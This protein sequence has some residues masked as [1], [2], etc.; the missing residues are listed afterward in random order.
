MA[1]AQFGRNCSILAGFMALGLL[2]GCAGRGFEQ[3]YVE[4]S[5][6][7]REPAR[8]TSEARPQSVFGQGGF[9]LLNVFAKDDDSPGAGIGVRVVS[10]VLQSLD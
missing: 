2:A 6:N 8:Y 5:N 10:G 9:D 4:P 7:K 1:V 3:D